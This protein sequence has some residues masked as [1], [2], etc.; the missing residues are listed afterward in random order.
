M[1]AKTNNEMSDT[2]RTDAEIEAGGKYIYHTARQLERE[3]NQAV[4]EIDRHQPEL[5]D[6]I[7]SERDQLR[8]RLE[9]LQRVAAKLKDQLAVYQEYHGAADV[10]AM[11]DYIDLPAEVKGPK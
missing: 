11:A 9:R 2:P 6:E 7:R 1:A 4:R 3:L 10:L 5:C 8:E